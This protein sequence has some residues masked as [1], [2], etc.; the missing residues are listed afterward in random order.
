[1]NDKEFKFRARN[2]HDGELYY[3]EEIGMP[4][5]WQ[6]IRDGHMEDVE[7]YINAKLHGQEMYEGDII[8]RPEI[9]TDGHRGWGEMK[10]VVK[11]T[12]YTDGDGWT[13]M[14]YNYCVPEGAIL[15]HTKI[16]GNVTDNPELAE[17]IDV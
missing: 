11:F 6:Q 2:I 7:Q 17:G 3:S 14:A 5:F 16:I 10:Y 9:K 8:Y 12:E 15:E 4:N 1:M 13:Y